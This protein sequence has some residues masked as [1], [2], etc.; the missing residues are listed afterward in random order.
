MV[1]LGMRNNEKLQKAGSMHWKR[2]TLGDWLGFGFL[3]VASLYAM[4]LFITPGT[5]QAIILFLTPFVGGSAVL[6]GSLLWFVLLLGFLCF[7][8]GIPGWILHNSIKYSGKPNV[9]SAKG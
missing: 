6:I 8:V 5:G 1:E 7:A 2:L 4:G 3:W 9:E